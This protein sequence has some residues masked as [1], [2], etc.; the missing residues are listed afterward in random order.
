M[1]LQIQFLSKNYRWREEKLNSMDSSKLSGRA[2]NKKN[3]KSSSEAFL[4]VRQVRHEPRNGFRAQPQL[5]PQRRSQ[6][7]L[8]A[9]GTATALFLR[10]AQ[11]VASTC[12]GWMG[13]DPPDLS[14][15]RPFIAFLLKHFIIYLH[16]KLSKNR[17]Y[18][19]ITIPWTRILQ[20]PCKA[21]IIFNIQTI[22]PHSNNF[23]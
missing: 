13:S 10:G 5:F 20:M 2:D 19:F 11:S 12:T 6:R 1:W 22:P 14:A 17:K 8:S 4:G 3:K 21:F 7:L 23:S 9:L 18:S 16:I 15:V